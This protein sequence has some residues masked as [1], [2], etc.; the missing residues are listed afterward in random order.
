MLMITSYC[1]KQ[2]THMIYIILWSH[3]I[4]PCQ[5][6]WLWVML[7]CLY[8]VY[9]GK[10]SPCYEEMLLY[11]LKY[12]NNVS[13][14]LNIMASFHILILYKLRRSYHVWLHNPKTLKVPM[15]IHEATQ[16]E[17][18]REGSPAANTGSGNDWLICSV[19]Y[20]YNSVSIHWCTSCT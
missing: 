17:L 4:T 1:I 3:K 2:Y 16:E 14:H 18:S 6:L 11:L 10:I 15:F 19:I 20:K 5:A 7:C 12:K 9:H 13:D 8:F